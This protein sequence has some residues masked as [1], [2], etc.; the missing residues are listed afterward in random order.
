[1]EAGV[2]HI[3]QRGAIHPLLRTTTRGNEAE[4]TEIHLLEIVA[5]FF[6]ALRT[7]PTEL[8]HVGCSVLRIY[9]S[10]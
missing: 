10:L 9:N 2:M 8:Q 6:T 7:L 5:E 1:M 3:N 4:G